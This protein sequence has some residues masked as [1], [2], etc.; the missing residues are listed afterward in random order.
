MKQNTPLNIMKLK[1]IEP[2]K[3]KCQIGDLLGTGGCSTSCDASTPVSGIW[4]T[5][6]LNL[7]LP[8][9]S[10]VTWVKW[11]PVAGPLENGVG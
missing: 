9:S 3:N 4:T 1:D 6:G 5:L 8:F 10:V 11:L 2:H 7:A